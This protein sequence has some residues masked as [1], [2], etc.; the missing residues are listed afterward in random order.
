M[1]A[2]WL[3]S[4]LPLLRAQAQLPD[5]H[6]QMFGYSYGIKGGTITSAARDAQGYLWILGPRALTRFDGKHTRDFSLPDRMSSLLC[7]HN[8]RIWVLTAKGVFRYKDDF[9]GFQPL[10]VTGS[11]PGKIFEH[12]DKSVWLLTREGFL[13]YD[14]ATGIFRPALSE[15]TDTRAFD[16]TFTT[17]Y[18]HTFF[19]A[20]DS[21]YAYHSTAHRT[22]SLPL[23]DYKSIFAI[24]EDSVMVSSWNNN[25][26]WYNFRA[27]RITPVVY[28]NELLTV[29]CFT[30]LDA[31][32][33]LVVAAQGIFEYHLKEGTYIPLRFFVN[34]LPVLAGDY[35]SYAFTDPWGYAW[36]ATI[37]GMAR[38]PLQQSEFGLVRISSFTNDRSIAVNNVRRMLEDKQGNI[39]MATGAGF[40]S[41]Q[42]QSGKWQFFEPMPGSAKQLQHPSI[43]GMS[44]DGRYLIL[45]PTNFGPW[46]FEPSTK[47]YSRPRYAN[48]YVRKLAEQDFF[49][50]I[51]TLR[52]GHHLFMG[53]DALYLLDG[54]TYEMDT[55][56]NPAA[57]QNTNNAFQGTDG[58]VWLATNRGLHC[59]DADMQ[60][61]G[62]VSYPDSSTFVSAGYMRADNQLLF[63]VN[64]KLYIAKYA[65]G[66]V[67]VQ[68]MAAPAFAQAFINILYQDQQDVI[69]AASENGIYRFDP[70]TNQLQLFDHTD[71]VQGYGFNNNAWLVSKA[72]TLFFGGNNGI[73]YL[74]SPTLLN[75]DQTPP[76]I[77]SQ[78]RINNNDTLIYE[79]GDQP[80]LSYSQNTLDFTFS[81][82]YF[83]N[84]DKVQYRY[85]LAGLDT[86]WKF[87]G[88][89]NVVRL[90]S[91]PPGKYELQVQASLNGV[92]WIPA[93]KNFGFRIDAP[94]WRKWWFLAPVILF[95]VFALWMY[96]RNRN[97]K[98]KEKE[99]ELDTEQAINY[100]ASSLYEHQQTDHI[101]W[102]VARNCIGR[103][104]F[105]DCV[106]YLVDEERNVLVQKAAHGPKSHL[107]FEVKTP[108]EIP[109]GRGITG[110]VAA[111]GK[112][113]IIHD[114]TKDPRYIVDDKVRYSE[115]TV[116][117][118]F[119]DQVLGVI[120]CEHSQKRF[121][122][123]KHLS[124]LTTIASLCANKIARARAEA[125]KRAAERILMDTQQKMADMEMQALRAQMNPHFIFNCLNSINRYIVKSDQATA[126]LYLTKFA[127]LI[128]LILDNSNSKHVILSNELEALKLYIDMEALRFDKKFSYEIVVQRNVNPDSVEVPP[129][130]IQPYVENAIWHGL[131]HKQTV[132]HLKIELCMP[133]E[134]MLQCT[135]EDNGIGREKAQELKSKTA[136]TKKSLGMKIT[137]N[138]LSLLNKHAALNASVDIINLYEPD[139]SAAGTKVILKI[140]V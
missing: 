62:A 27:Q 129:L 132:G 67:I 16:P 47:R 85:Q 116:P 15:L 76:V 10:T 72:G 29:R 80:T 53:R 75:N 55:L 140:P 99:E 71:N 70:H 37:D 20:K 4:I 105:E 74:T 124:I 138:R 93:K 98:L 46:L 58:I 90:I 123:Q 108:L 114:T 109:V 118:V 6:L 48:E 66:K 45:G 126:S 30:R 102:D 94:Y 122:T 9:R 23:H 41:W 21:L 11:T 19:Y 63:A 28:N 12:R 42:Q 137:E 92:D 35:A 3:L 73:N 97:R 49:D 83:N 82:P 61:L 33:F 36:M 88:N 43:R 86:S 25:S 68:L 87:L 96:V 101:L 81:C 104:H 100:F 128:R 7:D 17:S 77:F 44:Y 119:G 112:A 91:L 106:I 60:Y 59:F 2:L 14:E 1:A 127:K 84:P 38:F 40:V 57:H 134:G 110:S 130:I 69:W 121:F 22:R 39:W 107:R 26:Y 136:T 103:L 24:N 89:N 56:N 120:D 135:I 125:E 95:G 5:Y 113:E 51:L 139:Q 54:R 111:T 18:G 31:N 133:Q 78:I 52:N 34:G 117:I 79:L 65:H 115:I 50:D 32:R 8:G 131:L 64:G 13:K